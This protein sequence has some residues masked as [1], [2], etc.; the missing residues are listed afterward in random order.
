VFKAALVSSWGATGRRVA[1]LVGV[2]LFAEGVRANSRARP[3]VEA[4]SATTGQEGLLDWALDTGGTGPRW[5]SE[6]WPG[7]VH[8]A[9]SIAVCGACMAVGALLAIL[10]ARRRTEKNLHGAT[11]A[12]GTRTAELEE[13]AVRLEEE[14]SR[15]RRLVSTA[16][17]E[18]KAPLVTILGYAGHLLRNLRGGR[19]IDACDCAER[20]EKT[21]VRM[22]ENIE[23]LLR[24]SRV[25]G[26]GEAAREPVELDRVLDE[27]IET[28]RPQMQERGVELRRRFA[29]ASVAA[30]RP[31]VVEVMRNLLCNAV[32]YGCTAQR[33]RIGVGSV[34]GDGEV[35]LYVSDN[36]AG[37]APEHHERVFGAFQR[38][39][40][41]REGTG[42]GLAIVRRIAESHGGRAW[43]ESEPGRGATFWVSLRAAGREAASPGCGA[44]RELEKTGTG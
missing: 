43:V 44:V 28:L 5:N 20:I 17:H 31:R 18:L 15:L 39:V 12:L 30:D 23:D 19:V 25:A 40:Q 36:G 13:S 10:V 37:I 22:R 27:V 3:R 2:G 16:S 9:R 33:P 38:L 26:G 41:D 34:A 11:A 21:G 35:R 7:W 8:D 14:N 24:L 32:R 42:L 6:S 29:A 4:G 1:A